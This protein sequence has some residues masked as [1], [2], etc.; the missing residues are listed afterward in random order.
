VTSLNWKSFVWA[1]FVKLEKKNRLLSY[2]LYG[3]IGVV[4]KLRG[5]DEERGV[6]QKLSSFVF[7][8]MKIVHVEKSEVKKGPK[9]V[10]VIIE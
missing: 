8:R 5:Q 6:G 10:I 1:K 3:P 7:V 2:L 4:Q 9:I